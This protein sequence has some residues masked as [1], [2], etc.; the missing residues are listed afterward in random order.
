MNAIDYFL[1][2][3]LYLLLFAGCYQLL[4]RRTTYFDLNRAYLLLS[5]FASLL[6][7]FASIPESAGET[8]PT[9]VITL[10]SITVGRQPQPMAFDWSVPVM[11]WIVYGAG[12]LVMLLRLAWRLRAVHQLI[13]HGSAQPQ[14]GYVLIRLAHNQ[15]ASFSFGRYLVLNRT[16]ADN[17]PAAL[18]RHEEAHIRQRHTIDVLI[19]EIAQAVFWFNPTL[20]YYKRALQEVHE[21]LA[22]KAAAGQVNTSYAHQLVSYALDAPVAALTTPFISFSTLKQRVIMLQKPASP[23]GPCSAMR[24][25]FP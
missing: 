10:P 25:C 9:G 22:D 24:W 12:T 19:L 6:L 23:A 4:L 18:L 8:L 20:L 15:V 5:L 17:P 3:T 16:D 1:R 21:F 11:L 13:R 7:P 2:S 14:G